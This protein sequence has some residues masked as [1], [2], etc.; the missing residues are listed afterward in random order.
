MDSR[1]PDPIQRVLNQADVSSPA[2][3]KLKA[4]YE[5]RLTELRERNDNVR[6]P[7]VETAALRGQIAEVKR[8]LAM[9]TPPPVIDP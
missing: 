2:W 9:E 3:Q 7:E 5:Q 1:L 6:L 4:F 8:F